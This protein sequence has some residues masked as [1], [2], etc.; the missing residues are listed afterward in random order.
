MPLR[1]LTLQH[2]GMRRITDVLRVEEIQ[3]IIFSH[4]TRR[5]VSKADLRRD[6]S[7]DVWLSMLKCDYDATRSKPSTFICKHVDLVLRHNA[8][9][10]CQRREVEFAWLNGEEWPT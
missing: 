3:C 1:I 5:R 10:Y 4:L 9:L 2:E 6:T 7:Q 8:H